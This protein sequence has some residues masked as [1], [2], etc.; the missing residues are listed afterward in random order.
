MQVTTCSP[1]IKSMGGFLRES[2]GETKVPARSGRGHP[3]P[4]LAAG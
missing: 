4:H 2:Q 3:V 1:K